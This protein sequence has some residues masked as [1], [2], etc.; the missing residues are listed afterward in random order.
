MKRLLILIILGFAL[1]W[2]APAV[3]AQEGEEE[4]AAE[5]EPPPEE[6]QAEAPPEAEQAE[7]PASSG[8]GGSSDWY[9]G[10]GF[11]YA[12]NISETDQTSA[13]ETSFLDPF[14][15]KL[16]FKAGWFEDFW[17]EFEYLLISY[18]V[19]GKSGV[20]TSNIAKSEIT[21]QGNS[22]SILA[23]MNGDMFMPYAGY[24]TNELGVDQS[25]DES[26]S[27]EAS[28]NG[29]NF[30]QSLETEAGTQLIFGLDWLLSE[31]L[32]VNGDLRMITVPVT[33][34][35]ELSTNGEAEQG[36]ATHDLTFNIM[37]LGLT[38]YY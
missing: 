16:S 31:S 20:S 23:K 7:A 34:S 8:G 4:Q 11:L 12:L 38:Y 13:A 24:G 17:V 5:E 27:E 36:G 18:E 25:V 22:F 15:P 3:W 14:F 6:E 30:S 33:V 2:S 9:L 37:N 26:V 19:S 21:F 29:Q 32:V 1:I 28:T 35:S 10:F